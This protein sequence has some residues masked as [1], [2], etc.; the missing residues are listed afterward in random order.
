M[1]EL[2]LVAMGIAVVTFLLIVAVGAAAITIVL[3]GEYLLP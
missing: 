2:I 1:I 3:L